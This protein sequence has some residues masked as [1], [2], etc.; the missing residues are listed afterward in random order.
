MYKIGREVF[1]SYRGSTIDLARKLKRH[2]EENGYCQKALICPPETFASE[3]ELMPLY[4][5]AELIP[6]IWQE[7]IDGKD[8]FVRLEVNSSDPRL[9]YWSSYWTTT[10][11]LHWRCTSRRTNDITWVAK[12]RSY[13]FSVDEESWQPLP[14]EI[15]RDL[16]N[17]RIDTGHDPKQYNR[18]VVRHY[19][20]YQDCFLIPCCKCEEYFLTTPK[21]IEEAIKQNKK[22]ICPHG[23]GNDS[24]KFWKRG[25][26]TEYSQSFSRQGKQIGVDKVISL[27]QSSDPNQ[28]PLVSSGN[29]VLLGDFQKRGLAFAAYFGIPALLL[30]GATLFD[31]GER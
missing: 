5:W 28:L 3:N 17:L 24:F 25:G 1:I 15:T 9:N 12:P 29:E 22:V 4:K 21:R 14:Y 30:L 7:G 8:G 6:R 27:M 20:K 31:R 2:L 10:E 16:S 19:S 23:C 11:F 26:K 13:G 18:L